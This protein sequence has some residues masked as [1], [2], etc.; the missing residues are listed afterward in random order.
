MTTIQCLKADIN[1]QELIQ[2]CTTKYKQIR[3]EENVRKEQL[4]NSA[5][6][7]MT[8]QVVN[9]STNDS[10]RCGDIVTHNEDTLHH[11]DHNDMQCRQ[12]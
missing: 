6:D 7:T 11:L 10:I 1:K 8:A 12:M 2:Q 3:Q 9:Q 5:T 4:L